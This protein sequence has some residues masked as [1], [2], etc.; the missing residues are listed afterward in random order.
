L[1]RL[2]Y[3]LLAI[4]M[5]I[6]PMLAHRQCAVLPLNDEILVP[7]VRVELAST[8]LSTFRLYRVCL[9][10]LGGPSAIRTRG[11]RLKTT[12]L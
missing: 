11:L 12:A 8:T 10:G 4:S 2:S 7:P 5:G 3:T 6:E 1:A 9:Q